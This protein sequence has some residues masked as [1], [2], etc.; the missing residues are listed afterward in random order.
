MKRFFLASLAACLLS[1]SSFANDKNIPDA[2]QSFYNAFR[3]AKNVN[4]TQVNDMLRI[5]FVLDGHQM[6]AYYSNDELVVVASE[7]KKEELPQALKA[8]L[9]EY[10]G[11]AV[12]EAYE[13]TNNKSKEYCVV[14]EN[15]SK[16]IILKG[17]NKWKTFVDPRL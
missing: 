6:F 3:S 9:S 8:Q 10:K 5:G 2:L 13:L 16:R 7:I 1:L 4:W 15:A 14:M 17:K 12:T 11:Y